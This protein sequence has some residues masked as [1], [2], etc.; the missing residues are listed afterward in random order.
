MSATYV[1]RH[2]SPRGR[3]AVLAVASLAV[4]VVALALAALA[5]AAVPRAALYAPVPSVSAPPSARTT[6]RPVAPPRP[7]QPRP[8]PVTRYTVRPGDTLWSISLQ[9]YGTGQDWGRI[10]AASRTVIG[11]DPG[12][13]YPGEQL[14]I[15]QPH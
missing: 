14:T 6:P 3:P 7:P 10:W 13:L 8:V 2:A 1:P 4:S 5:L 11:P 15:P 12:R 9:W